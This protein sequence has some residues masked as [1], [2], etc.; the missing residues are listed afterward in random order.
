MAAIGTLALAVSD[1][2]RLFEG[3]NLRV[4]EVILRNLFIGVAISLSL[5]ANA[6][7][8]VKIDDAQLKAI[9]GSV[10]KQLSADPSDIKKRIRASLISQREMIKAR[11]EAMSDPETAALLAKFSRVYYESLIKE[12]FSK[13]EAM[14]LVQSVGIP[15]LR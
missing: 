3:K 10:A 5:Q 9:S 2:K 11:L 12:G 8:S 15:S 1:I 7:E 6:E 14:K 4:E 13:G